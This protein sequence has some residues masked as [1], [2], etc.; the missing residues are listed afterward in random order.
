MYHRFYGFKEQPFNITPSSHFFFPSAKHLEA[1]NTLIYAIEERKGFVVITGEVGAGKTTICRALLNQLQTKTKVALITNTLI[2]RGDLLSL[3]L[4]DLG[5]EFTRRSKVHLLS[6]LN[7]YLIQKLKENN[8]VVLIIDEAQNLST[9]LLEEVRLLSNLE[10]ENEK[11]IQII[12]L[13]QP[14][15]R[16]KLALS[17]LKQLR[18][19]IAVY[20][21]L[22]PL[23]LEESLEYI[24]HRLKIAS[25][26]NRP[27]FSHK[28]LELIYEFS[29][30][31]P[32][33]INQIC[34]NALLSGYVLEAPVIDEEIIKEEIKNSP[35]AQITGNPL[36]SL[37]GIRHG[38]DSSS[39]QFLKDPQ[40]DPGL[41]E[42]D[43][44]L[45]LKE[46]K[47]K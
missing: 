36:N 46:R 47:A 33:L 26:T 22:M 4:E 25:G 23:S 7:R 17:R 30:G 14:E 8:N 42:H 9:S 5:V 32:R 3:I 15:L 6:H 29:K 24:R 13:G 27:Y 31:V 12:F 18:Q 38:I 2:T 41:P 11:L 37:E 21:H 1:L 34:D 43:W 28:A 44:D 45:P 10:T 35:T 16:E 19:R 20:Y 39:G 40:V